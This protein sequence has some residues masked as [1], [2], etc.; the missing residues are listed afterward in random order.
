M[1]KSLVAID[2]LLRYTGINEKCRKMFVYNTIQ[3]IN[4]PETAKWFQFIK[5]D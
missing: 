5:V 2:G 3:I 4:I 1:S